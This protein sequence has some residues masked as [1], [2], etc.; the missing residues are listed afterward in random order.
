LVTLSRPGWS[1]VTPR[2]I[3][4]TG[5]RPAVDSGSPNF[6]SPGRRRRIRRAADSSAG[7]LSSRVTAA[8]S[9]ASRAA[10]CS[11]SA[12]GSWISSLRRPWS[13]A[14]AA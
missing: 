5:A 6:S 1:A 14:I 11:P 13:G 10:G 12:A 9:R 3:T 8:R 2:A 4:S 7:S